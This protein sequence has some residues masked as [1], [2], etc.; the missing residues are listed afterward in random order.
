M[1][2]TILY[3]LCT[4]ISVSEAPKSGRIFLSKNQGENWVRTDNGFPEEASVNALAMIGNTIF[5]GTESDGLF[6]SED[7]LK[8]WKPSSKGLPAHAKINALIAFN[9]LLFAGTYL[10]GVF[11]SS[12]QG[13]SWKPAS[14]GVDNT[15]IRS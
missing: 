9:G 12:N 13:A 5:A 4:L 7:G 15:S 6:L 10:N 1:K 3:L 14:E 11:V 2:L 8:T